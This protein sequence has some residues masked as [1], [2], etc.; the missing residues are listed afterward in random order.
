M[1]LEHDPRVAEA[2]QRRE[3][4]VV[5]HRSL[6]LWRAMNE[7]TLAPMR[8]PRC[9]WG[10]AL[11]GA[12]ALACGGRAALDDVE[13]EGG[14]GGVAG[15]RPE[16]QPPTDSTGDCRPDTCAGPMRPSYGTGA[17]GAPVSG[18]AGSGSTSGLGGIGFGNGGFGG[19]GFAGSIGTG[20]P[21]GGTA[22]GG[23]AP[24]GGS[25]GAPPLQPPSGPLLPLALRGAT[26]MVSDP[27]RSRL[28]VAIGSGARAYSS[29]IVTFDPDAGAV[30]ADLPVTVNPD[31]LAISDDGST[32]W[33]GLHESSSV[34]KVDTSG[35]VPLAVAEYALPP[36]DFPPYPHHAGPMVVLPG[37][38]SSLAVSLH[39]DALSPSLA[40]VVVL[41]DGIP[42]P[43]RL[44][45]HTGAS[46]LTNGPDGYLLGFNNL[47]TGFGVYSISVSGDGLTQTEHPNL[48]AGFTTDIVY[49]SG[50][51]FGT[52]GAVISLDF[53]ES[54][55]LLGR[56]PVLGQVFP[57]VA[58]GVVWVLGAPELPYEAS[59]PTLTLVNLST[60]EAIYTTVYGSPVVAPRHLVRSASGVFAFIADSYDADGYTLESGAYWMRP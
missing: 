47:H 7:L 42:R 55:F 35:D 9:R 15:Q 33:V 3:C 30:I 41:D 28:Y 5:K 10:H 25:A 57:D 22:S 37:T 8:A 52:D 50:L 60:L 53:P 20:A 21:A 56:L 45:S 36:T 34:L 24:T 51:L 23:S 18:S 27:V 46:R 44:P 40:G 12:A 1:T 17:A 16:Q 29:S 59:S 49:E 13:S 2:S 32:L 19:S 11:L 26:T 48:I 54:P 58:A 43:Q 4:P 38:S 39:Y 14:G 31:A 6:G